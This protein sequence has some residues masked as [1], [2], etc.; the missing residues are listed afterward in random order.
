MKSKR[1]KTPFPK[2]FYPS[3]M[4]SSTWVC[5]SFKFAKTLCSGEP[6][7]YFFRAAS[8]SCSEEENEG[9]LWVA[10]PL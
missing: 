8:I 3:K 4:V 9:A 6:S 2:D 1:A 7:G 10:P 5:R